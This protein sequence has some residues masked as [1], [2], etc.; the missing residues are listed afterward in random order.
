MAVLV[1]AKLVEIQWNSVYDYTPM[2][3]REHII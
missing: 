1:T 2:W 3:Y